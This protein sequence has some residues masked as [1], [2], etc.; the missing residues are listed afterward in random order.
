MDF[1]AH[2]FISMIIFAGDQWVLAVIF[3][4]LPD[5]IPFGLSMLISPFRS[6]KR[7]NNRNRDS[8]I[9]FYQQDE[10]RWVYRLYNYTHS[11]VIWGFVF[12][13]LIFW[14]SQAKWFPWFGL[15]WLL[16]IL[17][18]IPTHEKRFFAPQFLTPFS[19]FCVD[20]KSWA[21][22]RIMLLTYFS[23]LLGFIIRAMQ[24]WS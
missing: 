16:H 15:A 11:L 3:G 4:V 7:I 21:T 20:G 24:Y 8:M 1:F 14:G 6:K 10:N 12:I 9:D 13:I 17:L 5:F 2:I 22:P 18:D 23:I 19:N